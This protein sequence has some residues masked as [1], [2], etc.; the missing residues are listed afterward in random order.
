MPSQRDEQNRTWTHQR[1]FHILRKRVPNPSLP[2][3]RAHL[4]MAAFL[5]LGCPP[6]HVS[7]LD[8]ALPLLILQH[9]RKKIFV[10]NN[11][12]K[13]NIVSD[14]CHK[15][16]FIFFISDI[17]NADTFD[18]MVRKRWPGTPIMLRRRASRNRPQRR[19]KRRRIGGSGVQDLPAGGGRFLLKLFCQARAGARMQA[20]GPPNRFRTG[21]HYAKG[22]SIRDDR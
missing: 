4:F 13:K 20:G 9:A 5:A 16:S 2:W 21:D 11:T 14:N 17:R 6:V 15:L 22:K 10:S 8:A 1:P 7:S 12:D 18:R 3:H 19:W